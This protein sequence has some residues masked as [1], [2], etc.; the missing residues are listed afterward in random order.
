MAVLSYTSRL[1]KGKK[2]RK[3]WSMQFL[4][5]ISLDM[6][7]TEIFA[8]RLRFC[9][10]VC[11]LLLNLNDSMINGRA[12]VLSAPSVWVCTSGGSGWGEECVC[13]GGSTAGCLR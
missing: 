5:F 1:K 9:I 8:E 2:K 3:M 11:T 6:K 12:S 4:E 13:V 7:R 10:G